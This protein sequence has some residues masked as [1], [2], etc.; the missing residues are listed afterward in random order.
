[1]HKL[2]KVFRSTCDSKASVFE[3]V[4]KKTTKGMKHNI[5]KAKHLLK[6]N[7]NLCKSKAYMSF[8]LSNQLFKKLVENVYT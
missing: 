8:F 2:Y 4:I 7:Q 3:K 5:T 6:G 1:M